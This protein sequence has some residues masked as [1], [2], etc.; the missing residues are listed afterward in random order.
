MS[1]VG[2]CVLSNLL[3]CSLSPGQCKTTILRSCT[4]RSLSLTSQLS[5][6][7]R[8]TP[9]SSDGEENISEPIKFSTSKASH[10]TWKVER[11]M[12]SRFQRPWWRVLP[13]SVLTIGFLLWCIF[14][15][16]SNIDRTLEKQLFEHLPGLL[17]N[18][19]ET[20]EEEETKVNEE[21]K[22]EPDD[23]SK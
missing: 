4:A 19:E 6:E 17:T 10:R 8:P 18:I 21:L 3:R 2:R 7:S 1:G 5:T 23:G 22:K 20:E 16:E 13:L 9:G 14:R 15:E 11:S 12:G